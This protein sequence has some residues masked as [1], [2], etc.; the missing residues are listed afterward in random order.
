MFKKLWDKLF[1][2]KFIAIEIEAPRNAGALSDESKESIKTL[3]FHPGFL[4]L[5]ARLKTQRSLLETTL[6]QTRLASIQE[7]EFLQSGIFWTKWLESQVA[8]QVHQVQ[9]AA[10]TEF[11]TEELQAL[12]AIKANMQLVGQ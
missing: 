4:A 3:A 8:A 1:P 10:A 11:S 7:V 2:T 9:K 6:K 5:T 12:E